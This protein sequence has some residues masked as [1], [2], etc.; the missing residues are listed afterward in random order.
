MEDII[1]IMRQKINKDLTFIT[2]AEKLKKIA[3]IS[4]AKAVGYLTTIENLLPNNMSGYSCGEMWY[5][6]YKGSMLFSYDKTKGYEGRGVKYNKYAKY[7][8]IV[9]SLDTQVA[10]QKFID[11]IVKGENIY[12]SYLFE[13][14][15][16]K[17]RS[18]YKEYKQ[19]KWGK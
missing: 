8:K 6:Y 15:I 16:D 12:S 18:I 11:Y 2:K 5:I 1:K 10:L 14:W 3:N 9:I 17:E 7:G 19:K 13:N 4:S